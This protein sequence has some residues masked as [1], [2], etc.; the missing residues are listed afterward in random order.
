VDN[1]KTIFPI[2]AVNCRNTKKMSTQSSS[3]QF[4]DYGIV[5]TIHILNSGEVIHS[6][7]D[8]MKVED[9][10]LWVDKS[11]IV[12]KIL[13]LRKLTE[14]HKRSVIVIYEDGHAIKEFVNVEH[15]FVPLAY[16]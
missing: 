10:F 13:H 7:E 5:N 4:R 9:R 1:Y 11:F 15:E 3:F 6:V 2:N 8:Y 14:D 16:C 12:A